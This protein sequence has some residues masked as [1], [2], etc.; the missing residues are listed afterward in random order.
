MILPVCLFA[1]RRPYIFNFTDNYK[2]AGPPYTDLWLWAWLIDSH[3]RSCKLTPS[4]SC[5][6]L[7]P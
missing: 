1:D 7:Y 5:L 6:I 2:S 3:V 4:L